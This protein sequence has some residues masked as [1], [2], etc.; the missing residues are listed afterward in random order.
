MH[1]LFRLL[2]PVMALTGLGCDDDNLVID[3]FPIMLQLDAGVPL[4]MASAGDGGFVKVV[5]DT[6]APITL[7]EDGAKPSLA[8]ELVTLTLAGIDGERPVPRARFLDATPI[9][10]KLAG[11]G[12]GVPTALS[13]VVGGDLLSR[14]AL[15]LDLSRSRMFLFPDI[16]GSSE[17]F[18]NA[19]HALLP[20]TPRGG[21]DFELGGGIVKFPPSRM[22]VGA[23]LEREA[24]TVDCTARPSIACEPPEGDALLVVASGVYPT[25]LTEN[26]YER[27][28]GREAEITFDTP[29]FLPGSNAPV[30]VHVTS[31]DRIALAAD[32]SESRSPCQ[33]LH[34]TRL[35]RCNACEGSSFRCSCENGSPACSAGAIVELSLADGMGF[36]VAVMRNDE[37]YIQG[38]R[39]EMRPDVA[40]VD[41]LMGASLLAHL[42]ADVDYRNARIII[43]CKSPALAGVTCM[44]TPRL[45]LGETPA[46]L[47]QT[48]AC[49]TK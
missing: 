11:V 35:M 2:L 46:C 30:L 42:V 29:L 13:G 41:G 43:R 20:S 37:K 28:L 38:L 10:A 49:T 32:E 7:M 27:F 26:A 39:N 24:T 5:I 14:L 6:A 31:L 34:V 9:F 23:C 40:D 36:P 1:W 18:H 4:A 21:G 45:P 22:L 48:G 33:E 12:M 3:P 17:S 47:F 15:R 25:V 8:R 19:C 44:T 16:G